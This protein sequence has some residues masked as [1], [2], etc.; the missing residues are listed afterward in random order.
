MTEQL[1]HQLSSREQP[2]QD[3]KENNQILLILK[4]KQSRMRKVHH[5][6]ASSPTEQLLE[7][8]NMA[9][10][11]NPAEPRQETSQTINNTSTHSYYELYK[12]SME[13]YLK[14]LDHFLDNI[15]RTSLPKQPADI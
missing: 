5:S 7:E 3:K 11:L 13:N 8:N 12:S 2:K 10:S 15:T 1:H 9:A 4:E 6:Y 14:H